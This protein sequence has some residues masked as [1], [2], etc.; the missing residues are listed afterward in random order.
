MCEEVGI[1]IYIYIY[2]GRRKEGRK[3]GG[4]EQQKMEGGQMEKVGLFTLP[5]GQGEGRR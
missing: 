4:R 5:N 3:E 2:A 1:Y